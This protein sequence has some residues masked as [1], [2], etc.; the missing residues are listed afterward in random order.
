MANEFLKHLKKEHKEVQEIFEKL[1]N[2]K[3]NKEELF[4]KLKKEL[5]PHLVAEEKVFYAALMKKEGAREDTL[6]SYEEHHVT[7][8]LFSEME[9][10]S[11]DDERWEAK[12]K[13]LK[14]LVFHHI[15]E[16]ER[17][18]FKVAEKELGKDEFPTIMDRFEKQS[19]RV[20]DSIS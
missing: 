8:K 12:L 2:G 14:E 6:E 3:G 20:R 5:L 1:E 4:T 15:K 17:K 7:E 13:V 10:M 16:E 19:E 18:L 9:K 11:R